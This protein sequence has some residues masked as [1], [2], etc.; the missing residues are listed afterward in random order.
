MGTSLEDMFVISVTPGHCSQWVELQWERA[1]LGLQMTVQARKSPHTI[2]LLSLDCS[3]VTLRWYSSLMMLMKMSNLV[4]VI[5][6]DQGR[7]DSTESLWKGWF[8]CHW[9]FTCVQALGPWELN[10]LYLSSGMIMPGS[11]PLRLS[12]DPGEC[13][14]GRSKT[15]VCNDV[16]SDTLR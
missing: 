4:N 6:Q 11:W 3:H 8:S 7:A 2:P 15:H 10:G 12:Q 5:L 1:N 14:M 9:G 16:D 13:L